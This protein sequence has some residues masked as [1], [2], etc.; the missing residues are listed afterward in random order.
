M[1]YDAMA[2]RYLAP[3][4]MAA[5]CALAPAAWMLGGRRFT[6]AL[7]PYLAAAA[8]AGWLAYG[9]RIGA[10]GFPVHSG[11]GAAEEEMQLGAELRAMGIHAAAADYWLAYRL[12]FLWSEDPVVAN[13]DGWERMPA[14]R[15]AVN[16]S[17][18]QALLFHPS[19]PQTPPERYEARLRQIGIGHQP[20]EIAGLPG[21]LLVR[22]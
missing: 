12:S 7:S 4:I 6:V 10:Y 14:Y 21:L 3:V 19:V 17:P 20:P 22:Q 11:R 13:I 5:P 1:P 8:I 16:R 15:A 18:R 2:V 9:A